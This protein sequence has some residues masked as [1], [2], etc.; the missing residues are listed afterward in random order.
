MIISIEMDNAAFQDGHAEYELT[1]MIKKALE[2]HSTGLNSVA[3]G[4][5]KDSP[6]RFKIRDYNGNACGYIEY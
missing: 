4:E 3:Q 5:E 2:H 6:D 1:R